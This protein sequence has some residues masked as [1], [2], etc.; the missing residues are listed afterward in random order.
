[1]FVQILTTKVPFRTLN[2]ITIDHLQKKNPIGK[3]GPLVCEWKRPFWKKKKKL[4]L[5]VYKSRER[6]IFVVESARFHSQNNG[7]V[8]IHRKCAEI[9][10]FS[11]K[12]HEMVKT[13]IFEINILI[14]LLVTGWWNKATLTCFRCWIRNLLEKIQ[15]K[16]NERVDLVRCLQFGKKLNYLWNISF[17]FRILSSNEKKIYHFKSFSVDA[18]SKWAHFQSSFVLLSIKQKHDNLLNFRWWNFPS[19][20]IQHFG[21]S[22]VLIDQRYGR[23]EINFILRIS[24]WKICE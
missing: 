16:R 19:S 17:D 21:K 18:N 1:M 24:E 10:I 13:I 14:K 20:F 2:N 23:I 12:F 4:K 15:Q 8:H 6:W 5:L 3:N 9:S 22:I 7:P 11:F